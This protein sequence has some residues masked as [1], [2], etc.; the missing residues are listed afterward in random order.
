MAIF[1]REGRK[2]GKKEEEE[3]K[4]GRGEGEGGRGERGKRG[5]EERSRGCGGNKSKLMPVKE[6]EVIIEKTERGKDKTR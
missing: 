2:R 5:D 6:E 4:V 1:L 3:R